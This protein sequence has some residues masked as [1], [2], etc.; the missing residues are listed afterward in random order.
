MIQGWC[1]DFEE[2]LRD[3][4]RRKGEAESISF[5]TSEE[6]VVG[7]LGELCEKGTAVT[8]QGART[9]LVA[10]AV[11]R[12]GHILNLSRMNHIGE[13]REDGAGGHVMSIG[14]GA[15]LT[16]VRKAVEKSG[17]FFPPDPTETSASIGGMVAANSSG[18]M[19]L[20]YG[21]TRNWVRAIRVA[22]IDGDVL[23]LRR[24]EVFAKGRSFSVTTESGRVISGSLPLYTQPDIKSAAGYYVVDDMDMIDLFIGMEGT[25][26]VVT[27]VEV[28]L[29]PKPKVVN[30]LTVFLPS[31]EGAT[32]LVRFMRGETVG[33]FEP[34]SL[35]AVAVEFFDHYSLD[36][37]RDMKSENSAF[38]D[39]PAL[40]PEFHTAVYAEF[41]ADS[42]EAIEDAVMQVMEVVMELGGSDD[43]TWY[44]SNP[45]ELEPLKA[46][47]HAVPE[48]V[49]LFIDGYKKDYPGLTKL[50]TDMS[51][52]DERLE[53]ALAM[54]DADLADSGLKSINYGHIG[55][56]HFHVNILPRNMDEYDRG[57]VLYRSWAEK[58][59]NMG[60]SVSA[61][62]GIGKLKTAFLE[63][64]YGSEGVGQMKALKGLFDPG[65]RLNSGNLFG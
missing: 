11:P 59:V 60:G 24:G 56:N 63:I 25:L 29:I 46:F 20:F 42:D 13:I 51:V 47:R 27:E 54:Y 65:M 4:S 62:H 41:H 43:D 50:G 21:P 19:S 16:E 58:I 1:G 17:L 6:Q 34:I 2:Y 30:G 35:R 61:E 64:M 32:K 53:E 38:A 8:V 48:A 22:L 28:A 10:G 55:A 33:G 40:R 18:A 3:E 5:P 37:L 15:I 45:R 12:S 7:I 52:P 57:W 26:G 39:I 31:A 14:P 44:A 9:G 23:V 36:L 49:L